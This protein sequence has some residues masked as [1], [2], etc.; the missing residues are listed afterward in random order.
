MDC[1]A[2]I[3]LNLV[4]LLRIF[5]NIIQILKRKMEPIKLSNEY[6]TS[7]LLSKSKH[8]WGELSWPNIISATITGCYQEPLIKLILNGWK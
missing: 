7:L 2:T 5:L 8:A 1:T 4:K 3:S 6:Y